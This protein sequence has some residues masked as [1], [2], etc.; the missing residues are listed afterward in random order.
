ML[1]DDTKTKRVVVLNVI[2]PILHGDVNK[3]HF[4]SS[5]LGR[6]LFLVVD[7]KMNTFSLVGTRGEWM[8]VC[9]VVVVVV[10]CVYMWV[11]WVVV[12]CTQHEFLWPLR[13]LSRDLG[14]YFSRNDNCLAFMAP[15]RLL[16]R[17]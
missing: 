4:F 14:R 12:Y 7:L 16:E 5:N 8:C 15:R 10:V 17:E 13:C 9:G 6:R 3:N 1:W 2:V 11:G